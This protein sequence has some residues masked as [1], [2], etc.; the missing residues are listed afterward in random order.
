LKPADQH[1]IEKGRTHTERE[2]WERW[3]QQ[4]QREEEQE[5]RQL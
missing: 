4:L 2:R 3:G 1:G 5:L